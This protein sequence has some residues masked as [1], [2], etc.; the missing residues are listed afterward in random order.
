VTSPEQVTKWAKQNKVN[1]PPPDK[2][3]LGGVFAAGSYIFVY[4]KPGQEHWNL[5]DTI[6]HES[7]HAWQKAMEYIQETSSGIEA[8]AYHIGH[9]ATNMLKDFHALHE[10]RKEGL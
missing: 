10:E 6:I 8:Q 5:V 9:I 2:D 3:N 4:V 7:V 1:I